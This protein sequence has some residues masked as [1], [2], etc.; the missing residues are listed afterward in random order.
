M[1]LT[2]RRFLEHS[3]LG[4]PGLGMLSACGGGGSGGGTGSGGSVSGTVQPLSGGFAGTQRVPYTAM[5]KPAVGQLVTDPDFGT[6]MRR[7]TDAYNTFRCTNFVTTYSSTQAWNCDETYMILYA[8]G[9]L[10]GATGSTWA[11]FNGMPPYNFIKFLPNFGPSDVEQFWWS[12]TDPRTILYINNYA[13]GSTNHSELVAYDVVSGAISAVLYDFVPMLT[14]L[15]WPSVGPVRAGYPLANGG[16]NVIWGLGAGGIPNINGELGLKA[17]G[18]NLQT[19]NH[20]LFNGI[21]VNE[22]RNMCPA[23]LLSANGWFWNDTNFAST[24]NYETWVFDLNG[25]VVRKLNFSADEH[26]DT[27]RNAAG[28]DLLVGVQFDTPQQGNLIV[29]NLSTGAISTLVGQSNGYGYTRTGSFAGSTCYKNPGWV[30]GSAIGSPYGTAADLSGNSG[31]TANPLTL[32]DQEIFIANVDSG[33]VYRVAHHRSTGDWSSASVSNY[34]SQPNVTLSPSGSRILFNSDW[35]AADPGN[36]TINPNAYTDTY[37]V[38]L[39]Q[40]SG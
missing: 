32:L 38:E 13:T 36:P 35:G 24:A 26:V 37:V 33:A 14:A 29:A 9:P 20:T 1:S 7:I 8:Q 10:S 18:F 11:L 34:W 12:Q 19:R 25:N 30:V 28:N 15:G 40:F 3:L 17:F 27:A 39:P 16:D 22:A 4:L 2:R 5:A 31:P 23:P 21:N 6:R